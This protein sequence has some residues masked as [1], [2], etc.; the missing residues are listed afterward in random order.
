ML[1]MTERTKDALIEAGDWDKEKF[2]YRKKVFVKGKGDM[3]TY[4]FKH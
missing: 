3:E 1:Q 2:V 4:Y